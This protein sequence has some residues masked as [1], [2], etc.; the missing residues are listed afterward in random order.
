[1]T[2]KMSYFQ[3]T[4]EVFPFGKTFG[5][6]LE[7]NTAKN[8]DQV[9]I[10]YEDR[11]YS[12]RQFNNIVDNLA[13]ALINLGFEKGDIIGLCLPDWPEY[14]IMYYAC[15]K[16]GVATTPISPRYREN[17]FK[18]M[19]GHSGAKGALIPSR[20]KD[21]DYLKMLGNIRSSLPSLECIFVEGEITKAEENISG[22]QSLDELIKRNWEEVYPDDYLHQ[23]YLKENPLEADDLLE[24]AYTS[25]TT[26]T[27]KG[28]MHSHNTRAAAAFFKR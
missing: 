2:E 10:I 12:Y 13:L 4:G 5:L 18:I 26:G 9:I 25:G 17:E 23:V 28:V 21:F 20:W 3:T 7:E 27:P 19:L 6:Y 24:V 15:A 1:M 11:Q 14:T 22:L 16:I 8:P